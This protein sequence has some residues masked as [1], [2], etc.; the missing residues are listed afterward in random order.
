[1]DNT[2]M[3]I[4]KF[5]QSLP[6]TDKHKKDF[7]DN[8]LMVKAVLNKAKKGSSDFDPM[9][10]LK[11][12]YAYVKYDK[13][14]LK[15]YLKELYDESKENDSA[16]KKKVD[17]I[18]L[19]TARKKELPDSWL[20]FPKTFYKQGNGI[21]EVDMDKS[22]EE[23]RRL[24]AEMAAK[25]TSPENSGQYTGG[26]ELSPRANHWCVA[27]SN[28]R[29][30]REYKEQEYPYYERE[31][32]LFVIIIGKNRDGSPN[33]NERYLF[34]DDFSRRTELADKFNNHFN[35]VPFKSANE[36][37]ERLKKDRRRFGNK[38]KA[39]IENNI[40]KDVEDLEKSA[41][42]VVKK[43]ANENNIEKM[44]VR[45]LCALVVSTNIDK[46][47]D[48]KRVNETFNTSKILRS[49]KDVETLEKCFTSITPKKDEKT[50]LWIGSLSK[51]TKK[52]RER[53]I[54]YDDDRDEYFG[55]WF[56][57]TRND[58]M[59]E[60]EDG[61]AIVIGSLSDYLTGE[62]SISKS[63]EVVYGRNYSVLFNKLQRL[64]EKGN[65]K[66]IQKD[67]YW[68]YE[69]AHMSFI[70]RF[71][72]K[73]AAEMVRPAYKEKYKKLLGFA[74]RKY[75]NSIS[76][77]FSDD[78]RETDSEEDDYTDSYG[79]F[80]LGR[81]IS[82]NIDIEI[83]FVPNEKRKVYEVSVGGTNVGDLG[84]KDLIEKVK[85]EIIS[86]FDRFNR[87]RRPVLKGNK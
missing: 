68:Y 73:N 9:I 58:E 69:N 52:E 75:K 79:T 63:V 48:M 4:L 35:S 67:K 8:V 37:L 59:Y 17:D 41:S 64:L 10:T 83:E 7:E 86:E 82:G 18:G 51:L 32:P 54:S 53:F 33:W 24:S 5:L 47:T 78:D 19:R 46:D 77:Y 65:L 62:G 85:K 36:F 40:E 50:G 20:I 2:S 23:I 70:N 72:V 3:A 71:T 12:A 80:R 22:Y 44:N 6:D 14:E 27:S 56:D 16:G 13:G 81:I 25:D 34:F 45:A 29:Y 43:V 28:K 15:D 55:V 49:I 11:Q 31:L 66:S 87:M 60:F 26:S 38:K 30:F 39:E 21:R 42:E 76:G 1:M 57:G 61:L 84:D 74:M